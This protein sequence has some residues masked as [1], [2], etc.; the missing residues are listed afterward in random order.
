MQSSGKIASSAPA[1]RAFSIHSA[2][3]AALPSTSPTV[4]LIWARATRI[5]IRG[6]S[7]PK[8]LRRDPQRYFPPPLGLSGHAEPPAPPGRIHGGAADARRRDDPCLGHPPADGP[9]IRPYRGKSA[10]QPRG[11]GLGRAEAVPDAAVAA[12]RNSAATDRPPR[13][14]PQRLLGSRGARVARLLAAL[15]RPLGRAGARRPRTGR[16]RRRRH[17]GLRR[18]GAADRRMGAHGREREARLAR[19]AQRRADR[20]ASG[21]DRRLPLPD[22]RRTV[23]LRGAGSGAGERAAP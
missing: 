3:L 16:S 5:A 12:G 18:A 1:S 11:A 14:Q 8:Y 6:G 2:T 22:R 17:P 13:P 23:R 7:Y 4:G 19:A 21:Q 15:L 10:R 9:G 20:R